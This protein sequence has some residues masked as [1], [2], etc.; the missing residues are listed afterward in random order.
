[1]DILAHNKEF[2][3]GGVRKAWIVV[4]DKKVLDIILMDNDIYL[5]KIP[6]WVKAIYD[7]YP[8]IFCV[9]KENCTFNL[10]EIK[11][12]AIEAG[13]PEFGPRG[14]KISPTSI[15]SEAMDIY[16]AEKKV[17]FLKHREKSKS[18]LAKL[19][20]VISCNCDAQNVYY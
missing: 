10:S 8:A 18:Y 4:K 9:G 7:Q 16:E 5:D 12:I 15:L 19:G 1:M 20:K 13:H 11:K 17:Q 3:W 2:L 6:S 14:G